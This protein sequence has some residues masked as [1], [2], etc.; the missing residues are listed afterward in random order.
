MPLDP[1]ALLQ[2]K[3]PSVRQRYEARDTILYAL[4]VG[5]AQGS[6][7]WDERHLRF[8]YEAN[9][10]ALPTL[11]AMLGDPGFWMRESDTGLDW[12]SLVHGEQFMQWMT[13]LPAA[14]EVI[15][16]NQVIRVEDRGAGRGALFVVER[17][18]CSA[19][20]GQ[21]WVRSQTTVMA[22]GNGGF[23][24]PGEPLCSVGSPKMAAAA[25]MPQRPPDHSVSRNTVTQQPLLYR[26]SSD[27]N[28]LHADPAVARQAGFER[29]IMHGMCTFGMLGML[30]VCEFCAFDCTRL[31]EMRARFTAPL[32]PGET[33]R[34]DFWQDGELVQF[35]ATCI[36]RDAVVLDFG[37]A[38]IRPPGIF[39]GA[40]A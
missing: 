24:S 40:P 20:S 14:A 18:I 33:I 16:H 30:L 38:R 27:L 29:P 11:C 36:E 5:A 22:R 39:P 32:Y 10:Q 1:Q 6:D 9:L 8:V 37:L 2:R 26:L 31:S 17:S 34:C 7:A 12:Q 28:P 3:L 35:R 25:P 19:L 13:P 21:C 15:G 4:G 23:S